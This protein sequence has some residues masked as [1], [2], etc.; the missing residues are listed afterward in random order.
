MGFKKY[1]ALTSNLFLTGPT[2]E[3]FNEK[4]QS[5]LQTQND[6]FKSV[7]KNIFN[8]AIGLNSHSFQG[9]IPLFHVLLLPIILCEVR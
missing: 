2:C 7:G 8:F 5:C 3:R 6:F 4:S 9:K 1:V